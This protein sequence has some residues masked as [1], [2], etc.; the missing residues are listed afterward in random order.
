MAQK[1]RLK[2]TDASLLA[3]GDGRGRCSNEHRTPAE[4]PILAKAT[5]FTKRIITICQG[6]LLLA[7]RGSC[8]PVHKSRRG[9]KSNRIVSH[10]TCFCGPVQQMSDSQ[11]SSRSTWGEDP[12]FSDS[13]RRLPGVP[14]FLW[15]S[16]AF[17]QHE[18]WSAATRSAKR[19]DL[20]AVR[21][22]L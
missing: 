9:R 15:R 11:T 14:P 1:S 8:S 17:R 21:G 2:G 22:L 12:E 6:R 10:S 16:V 7:L 19:P 20:Y 13:W 18:R 3:S 4:R 5:R